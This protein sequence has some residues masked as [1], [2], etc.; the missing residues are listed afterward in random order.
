MDFLSWLSIIGISAKDIIV[1]I[2]D[3]LKNPNEDYIIFTTRIKETIKATCDKY[4]EFI[5][6]CPDCKDIHLPLECDEEIYNSIISSFER[7]EIFTIDMMLPNEDIP[8]GERKRLY[9][10]LQMTL[11]QSLDYCVRN[12]INW[13]KKSIKSIQNSLDKL[14]ISVNAIIEQEELITN[15]TTRIN[16]IWH[17]EPISIEFINKNK[18]EAT[19]TSKYAQA[20]FNINDREDILYHAICGNFD[21]KPELFTAV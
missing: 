21:I 2:Q 12:L 11:S 6:I 14:F 18:N 10:L 15:V 1:F 19:Q 9:K 7:N 3:K 20:Y 17:I 13:S 8:I 16:K 5:N 4:R